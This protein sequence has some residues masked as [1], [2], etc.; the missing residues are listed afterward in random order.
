MKQL[1]SSRRQT[2]S[3]NN[4]VSTSQETLVNFRSPCKPECFFLITKGSD[5]GHLR[6]SVS[7]ESGSEKSSV[8]HLDQ[9]FLQ[10][11]TTLTLSSN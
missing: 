7:L 10:T 4:K 11:N 6:G 3:R 9:A 5:E 2:V 1:S 8:S